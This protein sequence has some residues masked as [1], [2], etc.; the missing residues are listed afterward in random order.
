M[1]LNLIYP[2]HLKVFPTIRESDR[3][4]SCIA[5]SFYGCEYNGN[6]FQNLMMKK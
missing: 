3:Q 4:S 5:Y 1:N 6:I 2:T